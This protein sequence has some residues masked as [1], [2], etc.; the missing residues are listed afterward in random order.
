MR[1]G[2]RITS[3]FLVFLLLGS[4]LRVPLTYSYYWLDQAGFIEQFCENKDVPEL[5]CDGKCYLSQM[6]KAK[7]GKE[8]N[9]SIPVLEWQE[10]NLLFSG[11]VSLK[12]GLSEGLALPG[13]HFPEN[14][15][16]QFTPRI[17]HPP[18]S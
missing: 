9:K 2:E 7:A 15:T 14:Y 16:Y 6:L 13:P 5:N 3:L 11:A 10:L 4:V 18:V 12:T 8:E 1:A 17:F